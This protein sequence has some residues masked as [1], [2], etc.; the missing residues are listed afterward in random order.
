MRNVDVDSAARFNSVQ[1]YLLDFT[2]ASL[3]FTIFGAFGFDLCGAV[4]DAVKSC[5][6]IIYKDLLSLMIGRCDTVSEPCMISSLRRSNISRYV[7][8]VKER[9]WSTRTA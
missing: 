8:R 2:N 5:V 4:F 1:L 6:D 9:M 3:I 7:N